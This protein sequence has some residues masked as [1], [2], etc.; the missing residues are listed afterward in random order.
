MPEN[1]IHLSSVLPM[2]PISTTL[3]VGLQR[4]LHIRSIMAS[5]LMT[6]FLVPLVLRVFQE[7]SY[8]IIPT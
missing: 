8:I 5:I 3:Q 1:T 2:P 4:I 6:L 7:I